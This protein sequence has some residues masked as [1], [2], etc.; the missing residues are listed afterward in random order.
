MKPN[1][2]RLQTVLKLRENARDD[3][4]RE[5][6]HRLDALEAAKAELTRRQNELLACYDKQDREQSAVNQMLDRGVQ[7]HSVVQRRRFLEELRESERQ[8][9]ERADQQKAAVL[10]AERDLD[11][12]RDALIEA[13][14]EFKAIET[15][16]SNWLVSVRSAAARRD[17]KASDEIG[18]ILYGRRDARY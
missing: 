6:A 9:K 15:H 5:V 3:A 18:N 16:R 10:R 17:Q 11:A 8:L 2:Y 12:A 14:R 1:T 13:T 4:G 7:V